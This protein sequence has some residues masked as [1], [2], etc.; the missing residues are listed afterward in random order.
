L[1]IYFIL[2]AN[3]FF[4]HSQGKIIDFGF[5]PEPGYSQNSTVTLYVTLKLFNYGDVS[6]VTINLGDNSVNDL[7]SFTYQVIQNEGEVALEKD[8]DTYT[9]ETGNYFRLPVVIGSS[10]YSQLTSV[11]GR[12]GYQ[13]GSYGELH[14]VTISNNNQ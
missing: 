10:A 12:L 7:G 11:S 3:A 13:D 4:A 5:Y 14:T 2:A 9:M 8:G 6:N 1:I